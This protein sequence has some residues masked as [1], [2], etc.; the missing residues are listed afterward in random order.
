VGLREEIRSKQFQH[1]VRRAIVAA[2]W[3]AAGD[4][5]DSH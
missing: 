5:H 4:E 3:V 2:Q 1:P